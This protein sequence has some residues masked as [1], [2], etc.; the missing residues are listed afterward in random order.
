MAHRSVFL[1]QFQE[2]CSVGWAQR[3]EVLHSFR[4]CDA[5]DGR[6]SSKDGRVEWLIAKESYVDVS[7]LM[8]RFFEGWS[9]EL[10][11]RSM[12]GL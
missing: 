2:Y 1:R 3:W 5:G 4:L 11:E 6:V 7:S 9:A 10:Y 8:F 12:D